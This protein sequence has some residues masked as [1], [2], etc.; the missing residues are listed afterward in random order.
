MSFQTL[1]GQGRLMAIFYSDCHANGWDCVLPPSEPDLIT[2]DLKQKQE[3]QN[4]PWGQETWEPLWLCT[5]STTWSGGPPG[6][7][8]L[9]VSGSCGVP[10]ASSRQ[11]ASSRGLAGGSSHR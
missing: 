11:T 3:C 1:P 2:T 10:G 4:V 9:A 6:G 7:S 8:G 5:C